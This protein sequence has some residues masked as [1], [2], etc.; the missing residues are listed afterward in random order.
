MFVSRR[1]PEKV[2][3]CTFLCVNS[4]GYQLPR[5]RGY[6]SHKIG[7]SGDEE[8]A[9]VPLILR[10]CMEGVGGGGGDGG[11]RLQKLRVRLCLTFEAKISVFQTWLEQNAVASMLIFE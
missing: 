10:M 1:F 5:S 4:N 6:I 9:K 3:S 2:R 11:E 8:R 7:G